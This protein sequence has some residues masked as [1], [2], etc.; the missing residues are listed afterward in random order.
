MFLAGLWL[1]WV[2]QFPY[3]K[4]SS[5][6]EIVRT[7]KSRIAVAKVLREWL[8]TNQNAKQTNVD[9]MI[10]L[11]E[12]MS[13]DEGSGTPNSPASPSGTASA[14]GCTQTR[15]ALY[16]AGSDNKDQTSSKTGQ[17]SDRTIVYD[18]SGSEHSIPSSDV[19]AALCSGYYLTKPNSHQAQSQANAPETPL[20]QVDGNTPPIGSSVLRIDAREGGNV[21]IYL[22]QKDLELIPYPDR[23]AF[24]RAVGKAWCD[25]LP[26]GQLFLPSVYIEDIR[27]GAEWAKYNCLLN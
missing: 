18:E 6:T 11:L 22:R 16:P 7:H 27:T 9:L 14:P 1:Y 10:A 26:E 3:K 17:S 20:S 8:V 15:I 25:N 21:V 23:A 5:P 24:F 13:G 2:F 12:N 4:L 19:P